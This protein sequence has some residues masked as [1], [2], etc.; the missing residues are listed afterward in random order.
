MFRLY[1]LTFS[2]AFRGTEEQKSHLHESP[3]AMTIPLIILAILSIAGGWIGI[4]GALMKGGDWLTGFLSPVI[5]AAIGEGVSS[6]TEISLMALSTVL[7]IVTIVIAW[8]QF[9]RYRLAEAKG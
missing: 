3:L 6:S 4:P 5:P 8:L 9:R 1:F 2:G 7:V